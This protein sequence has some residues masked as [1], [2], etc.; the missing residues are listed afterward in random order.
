M[1]TTGKSNDE[2]DDELKDLDREINELRS[3]KK[4]LF[5]K[6]RSVNEELERIAKRERECVDKQHRLRTEQH[7][8]EKRQQTIQRVTELES[9]LQTAKYENTKLSD[10][11]RNLKRSLDEAAKYSKA[12]NRKI[13]ELE[14]SVTL[15]E[16]QMAN[17]SAPTRSDSEDSV[18][19][20]E[21]QKQLSHTT[22][23]LSETKEE[24]KETRQRLSGVQERLT[25]SEQVTAAT[26][27]RKLQ[28][29]GNSEQLQLE[30]T[31]QHQ[32]TTHA[33]FPNNNF[34]R[35]QSFICQSFI[36]K[37]HE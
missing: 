13:N 16:G 6:T 30:L 36:C 1:A 2:V 21:L 22:K 9:Q 3:A 27:L 8:R 10:K 32:P 4:E 14:N 26:Q 37:T 34:Y 33:G 35:Y 18:A 20:V 24:L 19:V 7:D 11:I 25:V 15:A 12:Q 28:E 17:A 29:C 23:L 5:A 31:P